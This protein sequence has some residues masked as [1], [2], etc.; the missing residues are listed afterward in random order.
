MSLTRSRT[1]AIAET[2]SRYSIPLEQRPELTSDKNLAFAIIHVFGQN[3]LQPYL[4]SMILHTA[5]ASFHVRILRERIA[6]ANPGLHLTYLLHF[7]A[8]IRLDG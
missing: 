4:A 8:S 3:A 1:V 5:T 6:F 7:S 2:A